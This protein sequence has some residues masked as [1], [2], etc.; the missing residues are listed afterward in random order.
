MVV[1]H[2]HSGPSE[3]P[4]VLD[5]G[6]DVGAAVVVAAERFD[7]VEIE[8]RRPPEPWEGRHVAVRARAGSTGAVF[9]ALFSGLPAGAY[10][11]RVRGVPSGP[12]HRIVVSGGDIVWH[13]W[14]D[15]PGGPT[16]ADRAGSPREHPRGTGC[17]DE[18]GEHTGEEHA[19]AG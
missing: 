9:A 18:R 14:D 3:G 6:G 7:G 17:Q 13:D 8:I 16:R 2:E 4:A 1:R 19:H 12:V 5:I 10:E 15:G 11:L